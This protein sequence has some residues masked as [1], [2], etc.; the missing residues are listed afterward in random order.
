MERCVKSILM[1]QN[2]PPSYWTRVSRDA[3][4]LLNRFP[5]A[6][7]TNNV[8]LDG[9]RPRPLELLTDS[10]YSRRQ[11]DRELEY[12]VPCGTP[13]L[14]HCHKAKGSTLGPKARWG[15][16]SGMHRETCHFVCPFTKAPL[17]RS[18]SFVAYKLERGTNFA[19]F[20]GLR[21]LTS[22]LK[23]LVLPEDTKITKFHGIY[24]QDLRFTHDPYGRPPPRACETPGT[25]PASSER[26]RS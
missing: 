20:L 4:F 6:S 10:W 17:F 13:C 21:S 23:S 26:T 8:P 3:E 2:L 19:Q 16:A 24:Q 25:R 9:D 22:T 12:Y 14:V 1:Q 7:T 11:I 15:I 5:I 18:K